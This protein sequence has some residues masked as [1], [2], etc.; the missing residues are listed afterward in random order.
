MDSSLY[1]LILTGELYGA[2]VIP[3][4]VVDAGFK[5]A[6][7]SSREILAADCRDD[8]DHFSLE[9]SVSDGI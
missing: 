8:S 3:L 1:N 4:V 6:G 9:L 5:S 7:F 2:L